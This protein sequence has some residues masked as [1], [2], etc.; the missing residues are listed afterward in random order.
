MAKSA[1]RWVEEYNERIHNQTGEE[2]AEWER[3]AYREVIAAAQAEARTEAL[4]EAA[5]ITD[6]RRNDCD[7]LIVAGKA[8][9]ALKPPQGGVK[10]NS[11]RGGFDHE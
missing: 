1:D 10:P 2:I 3:A 11:Q 9:R 6:R 4:E 7:H 5:K 8:I